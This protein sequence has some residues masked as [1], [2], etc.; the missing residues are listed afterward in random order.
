MVI[1]LTVTITVKLVIVL[2]PSE[3]DF[4]ECHLGTAYPRMSGIYFAAGC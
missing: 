4:F 3:L 1:Y 2:F